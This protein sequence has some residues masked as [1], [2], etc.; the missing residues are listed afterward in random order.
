MALETNARI[1]SPYV[2]QPVDFGGKIDTQAAQKAAAVKAGIQTKKDLK[3]KNA[4]ALKLE[5]DLTGKAVLNKAIINQYNNILDEYSKVAASGENIYDPSTFYGGAFAKDVTALDDFANQM[6]D[7]E[8]DITEIEDK[9]A[10]DPGVYDYFNN[11]L[12][13]AKLPQDVSKHT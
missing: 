9:K 8:K 6:K 10:S 2:Y 4:S 12:R 13:E 1:P 7:V 3:A 11:Q 5:P